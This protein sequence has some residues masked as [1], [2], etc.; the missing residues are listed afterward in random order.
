ML[1]FMEK[2]LEFSMRLG[3]SRNRAVRM[4]GRLI[5]AVPL[6]CAE[7]LEKLLMSGK[8]NPGKK[9]K[10]RKYGCLLY[11]SDAADE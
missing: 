7:Y 5:G 11:T 1:L 4:A 8:W 2:M 9:R 3:K 10:K 6:R